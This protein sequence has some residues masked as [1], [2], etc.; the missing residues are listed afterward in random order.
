M[1]ILS[2]REFLKGASLLAGSAFL[3]ACDQTSTIFKSHAPATATRPVIPTQTQTPVSK[4]TEDAIA[5]NVT[6]TKSIPPTTTPTPVPTESEIIEEGIYWETTFTGVL[7]TSQGEN[8]MDFPVTLKIAE[9]LATRSICPIKEVELNEKSLYK[10]GLPLM[11]IEQL[12]DRFLRDNPGSNMTLDQFMTEKHVTRLALNSAKSSWRHTNGLDPKEVDIFPE[13]ATFIITD[14]VFGS[15]R[16]NGTF[17]G[18]SEDGKGIRLANS[19]YIGN[20]DGWERGRNQVPGNDKWFGIMCVGAL[21]YST[22]PLYWM[23]NAEMLEKKGFLGIEG[24]VNDNR[25]NKSLAILMQWKGYLDID[26]NFTLSDLPQDQ[27]EIDYSKVEPFVYI[28]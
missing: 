11:V 6:A 15:P 21:R 14:E 1:R 3:A 13:N 27:S 20:V 17:V 25:E 7:E 23:E 9:S 5:Q 22:K 12:Y 8:V 19:T 24:S 16:L 10:K 18:L 28:R 4:K 2:R 26:P